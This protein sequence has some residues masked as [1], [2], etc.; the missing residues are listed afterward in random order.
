MSDV[1]MCKKAAFERILVTVRGAHLRG[2]I[3]G[4]AQQ[5]SH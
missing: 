4:D 2:W 1:S 3:R 5:L